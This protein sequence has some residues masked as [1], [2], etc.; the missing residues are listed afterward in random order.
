MVHLEP[1]ELLRPGAGEILVQVELSAVSP[2]TERAQYNRL[3]GVT[4]DPPFTPGYSGVGRVVEAGKGCAFVPGDRVAGPF[5]H[6]SL[7][8]VAEAKCFLVP[9]GV[10]PER[11]ALVG[12]GIIALH[13]VRRARIAWGERVLVLG[14]GILGRL[15]AALADLNGAGAVALAG[16]T[17]PVADG[18]FDVVL[19]VTGN[20]EALGRA[21]RAAAPG[22]RLVLLGSPRGGAP[23]FETE[24]P[25]PLRILGVHATQAGRS[26][27]GVQTD[28][29]ASE[30]SL[31]LEWLALGRLVIDGLEPETIDPQECWSFYRRLGAGRPAVG[32]ALFDWTRL[33]GPMRGG[34]STLRFPDAL[35]SL[36]PE[37]QARRLRAGT[38]HRS[39]GWDR[40]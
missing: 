29:A 39:S 9:S 35:G 34:R 2:G 28:D 1:F 40:S 24:T 23:P 26:L 8:T 4:I 6:Q 5:H 13:G 19:D 25:G 33:P 20:P 31:F 38:P 22:G 14:R 30:G 12:L 17:D 27:Q 18:A 3:P 32:V 21:A 36:D 7:E 16:R 11:A 10:A 15:A 37:Q